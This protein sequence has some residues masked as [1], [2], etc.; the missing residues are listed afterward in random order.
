MT[1]EE[2]EHQAKD[3]G[4]ARAKHEGRRTTVRPGGIVV[5]LALAAVLGGVIGG[6]IVRT[7][8]SRRSAEGASACDATEVAGQALPSTVTINA[9]DGRQGGSGSGVIIRSGGYIVTNDHVIAIAAHGGTLSVLYSDGHT[10]EATLV[11]RDPSTDLAVVKAADGAPNF[12]VMPLGS[13]GSLQVGQ[14]VVALGAP[15]GLSST[16]TAG[17]VSALGRTVPVPFDNGQSALIIG[18][19]QTDAS[20][21][22]GN[23]G[24][25]LVD[26]S[27]QL[28]GI[29]TAGATVPNAA[30]QTGGGS[31]GLGFAIP[32]DLAQPLTTELIA[33]GQVNHPGFGMQ[34]QAIPPAQAQQAGVTPGL[35]V[36]EVTP[37]GPADGA[38]IRPGDIIVEIDGRSANGVNELLVTTLTKA[39][40]DTVQITYH[41]GGVA[42][43]T[44]L[45]LAP[46]L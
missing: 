36:Q 25:A 16:V 34:V 40:G 44:D 4:G 41:R 38:G 10:S 22:P 7:T 1:G 43:T 37:G 9:S 21:N 5:G 8:S 24:G 13:S 12:P 46:R 2:P 19:I 26:C 45:T 31:V 14:P 33:D 27:A 15:L 32:V 29:N 18:A 11:G 35:Y 28:V 6:L 20:I 39:S 17:I 42:A 30:G 3:G 23:S